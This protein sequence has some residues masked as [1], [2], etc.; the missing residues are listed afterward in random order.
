MRI[1]KKFAGASCIGK[2]VFMP[3]ERTPD[4]LIE[5]HRSR[6]DLEEMA[7]KFHI[8]LESMRPGA[9]R[10]NSGSSSKSGSGS[11]HQSSPKTRRSTTHG[12]GTNAGGA[13][14]VAPTG[15]S[16]DGSSG[17][18]RR[19][20]S[21]MPTAPRALGGAVSGGGSSV[22]RGSSRS[23]SPGAHGPHSACDDS[24][25]H[26]EGSPGRRSSWER[27]EEG[28]GHYDSMDQS[29]MGDE[30]EESSGTPPNAA[31]YR[32]ADGGGSAGGAYIS[33]DGGR[34]YRGEGHIP[35]YSG[36]QGAGYHA[37]GEETH[38]VYDGDARG[39]QHRQAQH[40]LGAGADGFHRH[41]G[42]RSYN[43]QF[44]SAGDTDESGNSHNDD[45]TEGGGGDAGRTSPMSTGVSSRVGVWGGLGSPSGSGLGA[46]TGAPR[47]L[48]PAA[49][50]A[51]TLIREGTGSGARSPTWPLPRVIPEGSEMSDQDAGGLLIGFFRS[52]HEKVQTASEEL[53]EVRV[54]FQVPRFVRCQRNFGV[55]MLGRWLPLWLILSASMSTITPNV[56][57]GLV[58]AN[59][60][61]HIW[62]YSAEVF[63]ILPA[64]LISGGAGI[65]IAA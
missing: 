31:L 43:F 15:S 4:N 58:I 13:S 17:G 7:R 11:V 5:T 30:S 57:A 9:G 20:G 61:R 62:R 53:G 23:P 51:A 65:Q 22:G 59:N 18:A 12:V 52:V 21:E 8:R 2:R 32:S 40:Q 45:S 64:I 34:S 48:P 10:A 41:G 37:R 46:S 55:F 27:D 54:G 33:A 39:Q 49:L 38:A 60:G 26:P 19:G 44:G 36:C 28:Y 6:R 16:T 24:A 25:P 14:A 35:G 29:P 63:M 3:I 42:R 50:A 56:A 1:T 47:T